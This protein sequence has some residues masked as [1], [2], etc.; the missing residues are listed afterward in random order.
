MSSESTIGI[1]ITE[2]A[3][4][5]WNEEKKAEWF[6][7]LDPFFPPNT[8]EADWVPPFTAIYTNRYLKTNLSNPGTLNAP[9][10]VY[11]S[12]PRKVTLAYPF[13]PLVSNCEKPRTSAK[14]KESID[15]KQ[16]GV[17]FNF[18]NGVCEYTRDY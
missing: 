11:D 12:L 8:P 14:Y 7:Y 17:K 15:P 9:N 5:R 10:L 16:F 4:N 2:D 6:T 18:E 1:S 13:G 3:A